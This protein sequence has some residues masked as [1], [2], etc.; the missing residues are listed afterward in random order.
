MQMPH[1]DGL[2]AIAELRA[3]DL[4]TPIIAL[5]ADAMKGDRERCLQGGCDDYLSK[6]IDHAQMV[7]MV[8]RYSEVVSAD[9]LQAQRQEQAARYRD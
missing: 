1:V 7:E 2:K 9:A 6:P 8:W 5:T 4:V 3:A